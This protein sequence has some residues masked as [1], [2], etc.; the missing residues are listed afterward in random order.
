MNEFSNCIFFFTAALVEFIHFPNN[1]IPKE[2]RWA[3][4]EFEEAG[5]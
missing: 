5:S 1:K 4:S 2:P 3:K